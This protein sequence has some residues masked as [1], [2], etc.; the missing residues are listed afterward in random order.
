MSYD[1]FSVVPPF[2]L[3]RGS[4]IQISLLFSPVIAA[5]S[6][7]YRIFTIPSVEESPKSVCCVPDRLRG[8]PQ[9]GRLM[10]IH[11]LG[12]I[13]SGYSISQEICTRFC[14][15]LLCCGY[16]IVHNEFT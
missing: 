6:M 16:A 14:Y 10:A 4:M 13:L 12:I 3:H 5:L 1:V 11:E 7:L 9:I 2:V 15:A 8:W